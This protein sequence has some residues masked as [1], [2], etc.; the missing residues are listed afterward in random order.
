MKRSIAMKRLIAAALALS[1]F[2]G[3]AAEAAYFH[4]GFYPVRNVVV[5]G[6]RHAWMRGEYFRPAFGRPMI[7]SNW[8][9]YHLRR[10]P[11]GYYWVR[12]GDRFLL[13][14]LATGLIADIALMNGYG[15]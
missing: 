3:T 13:V 9:F 15:Y 12:E 11:I 2:G 6:P 8:G 7:I 1:L 10:P 4:P 5:A 14:A